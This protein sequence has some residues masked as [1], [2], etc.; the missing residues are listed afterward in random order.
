MPV[1]EQVL[2]IFAGN[3]GYLDDLPLSDVTRFAS[4]LR[5]YVRN[6]NSSIY[7]RIV[8][9]KVLSDEIKADAKS[10]IEGFKKTFSVSE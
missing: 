7:D 8:S 4:E 3:E 6:N 1:A 10:A 9:E 5:E 2:V